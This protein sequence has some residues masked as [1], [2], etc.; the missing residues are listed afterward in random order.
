[1]R[2]GS[3]FPAIFIITLLFIL[4]IEANA[5]D[6]IDEYMSGSVIKFDLSEDGITDTDKFEA[7]MDLRFRYG[8]LSAFVRASSDRPFTYQTDRFQ[9]QKRGLNFE[10]NDD[11]DISVGD[12]SLIFG[13][14][15]ALNAI[16]DRPVDKDSEL[17]GAKIEGD[18]GFADLTLFWGQHRS[19]A[20][21]YFVSGVNTT[22]GDP[23]D[24]LFGGR[25]EFELGDVDLGTSYIVTD[26]VRW[27]EPMFSTVV[28]EADVGF[29]IDNVD[30]YYE[31]AWFTRDEPELF[32]DSLDGR[33]Q[34]AEFIYADNGFSLNGS[35]VRYDLAHFEYGTAPTLK[36]FDIDDSDA[37]ADDETGWRMDMHYSP[38][39]WDGNSLR[40]L[41]A[42]LNGIENEILEFKNYFI[43]WESSPMNDWTGSLSYDKVD[44]FLQ[45]Y[46]ALNGSDTSFRGSVDG[47]FPLG[48]TFHFT[49]RYRTL[50]AEVE[51]DDEVEL[52]FDWH[53]SPEFTVGLFRE[54]S[55]REFEPPPPGLYDISTDSP[56]QWN[57]AF[58]KWSPDSWNEFELRIGS[59]RG[60]F[61]CSGGTCAQLPPF[62]GIRLTYYRFL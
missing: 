46:G 23:S 7:E 1:M 62:K 15:L 58:V 9:I 49:A 27:G 51:D 40:V 52:G 29:S 8:T 6:F 57:S 43:E 42:D 21:E 48:G 36:R 25:L 30:F 44:G 34:L 56:G 33:G 45:F 22:D 12:Y 19:D 28:T 26:I 41:Y 53:V 5:T 17:D 35:W 20:S 2:S 54:T 55:T 10:L 13:R 24:V 47:P 14:G 39:A 31:S 37:N 60:G 59:E 38:D 16:E 18:L 50:R 3:L 61:Q 4:P 11:W 32:E